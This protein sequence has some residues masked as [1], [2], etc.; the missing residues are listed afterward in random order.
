MFSREQNRKT[1]VWALTPKAAE[2]ALGIQKSMPETDIFFS[3]ALVKTAIPA[4]YFDRLSDE[5]SLCFHNY[6]GHIFIMSAGIAVRMIA[7]LLCH[8]TTDPAVVV[9]DELGL[10]AIS[11]IS[12]HI[13]GANE[14]AKKIAEITGA[15][16]VIT[17]ATDINQ[18]PAI[19][20]IAKNLGLHIENPA[21]IKHISMALLTGKKIFLHDPFG[22]L[23]DKLPES[24]LFHPDANQKYPK[25]MPGVFAD[26]RIVALPDHV[27]ILR[28]PSLAAG[29]GC[30]RGTETE[31]MKNLLVET[32][33]KYDLS[34]H[35]LHTLASVDIKKDETGLTALAKE[36]GID[37]VFYDRESLKQV[38]GIENPSLMVEKH[39]GVPSV[40]E[41]AAILAS[42]NGELIVP[43]HSSKN[44]TVAIA[45]KKYMESEKY[46]SFTNFCPLQNSME[47][48]KN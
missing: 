32:L 14:L 25:N 44:V 5:I 2:L 12:G 28:P 23:T 10:H 34:I 17:T 39:I 8:K 22:L 18:V 1:A 3:S 40:C 24:C 42:G 43:K 19:D 4:I 33:K 46:S 38:P 35:S 15:V 48:C 37:P 11:L 20:L 26:D 21:A 36:L 30:N 47:E 41:A 27:L 29:M 9:M 31:E 7:P 16:P 6:S 13:G 45:R